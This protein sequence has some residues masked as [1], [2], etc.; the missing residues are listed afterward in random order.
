MLFNSYAFL[1]AFLPLSVLG[2]FLLGRLVGQRTA[3]AWLTAASIAFYSLWKLAFLPIL[4]GSMAVN[5][6][7]GRFILARR[8]ASRS[9]AQWIL[10]LG[11]ISNL[12]LLGWFKYA[13]F[14]I[15]NWNTL[16]GATLSLQHILLPLG[17]S[18][19]TFTQIAFLVDCYRGAAREYSPLNYALFVTFFPHLLAGPILHHKEMM[20]QFESATA[21]HINWTNTYRGLILIAIGLGKKV[22]LADPIAA[23]ANEGFAQPS[24]LSTGDAWLTAIAYT[25][26][27]YFDF[28][29]YCDVAIGAALLFNIRLPLNFD[30]PYRTTNLQDFWRRWHMTLSRFLRDYLYV[31]LGGNR[32]GLVVS[33]AAVLGTFTLG[34]LWHGANWTYVVW[35]A[36]N[37]AGV[38]VVLLWRRQPWRI[39]APFAWLLTMTFTVVAWV[40]FRAASIQDANTIVAAMF[41]AVSPTRTTLAGWHWIVNVPAWSFPDAMRMSSQLSSVLA[42]SCATILALWPRNS[43]AIALDAQPRWRLTIVAAIL[44]L[45]VLLNIGNPTEFIYFIF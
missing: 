24:S 33:I 38:V 40:Y 30:S 27:L 19:F 44:L 5:Y 31:P 26:Q 4:L 13:D 25:L 14:F 15:V 2:Y 10:A 45:V 8:E 37:G 35:G 11:V 20:P 6:A 21:T 23:L 7:L 16:T 28:S 42:F 43:Q 39:P 9:S 32:K 12:G 17:I 36:L 22:L 41:G 1:L 3:I 29:G 34:G 18:F